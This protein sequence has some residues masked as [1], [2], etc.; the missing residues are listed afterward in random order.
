MS[1]PLV[2]KESKQTMTE[3]VEKLNS[4]VEFD[5]SIDFT[6]EEENDD[7]DD[8]WD[9]NFNSCYVC[10]K[11]WYME[12][13]T[14]N[15]TTSEAVK[16]HDGLR[17]PHC[18]CGYCSFEHMKP[19]ILIPN[20]DK[21]NDL[22]GIRSRVIYNM[23][24]HYLKHM[25]MNAKT[26]SFFTGDSGYDTMF[27]N[28]N[29]SKSVDGIK[30]KCLRYVL[31][32]QNVEYRDEIHYLKEDVIAFVSKHFNDCEEYMKQ[33]ANYH[34]YSNTDAIMIISTFVGCQHCLKQ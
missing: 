24:A 29:I 28:G 13:A 16:L 11:I 32:N 34:G 30:L 23:C 15:G 33:I 19:R 1:F 20:E 18:H 2:S 5:S 8:E 22:T 6:T 26:D 3:L 31:M 21:I 25:K 27:I 17:C 4:I 7:S 10:D 9:W 12:R 14:C